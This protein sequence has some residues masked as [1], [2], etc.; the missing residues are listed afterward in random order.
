MCQ[1]VIAMLG[2]TIRDL[3]C[4]FRLFTS[5]SR[6]PRRGDPVPPHLDAPRGRDRRARRRG[7]PPGERLSPGPLPGGIV[8]LMVGLLCPVYGSD[9]PCTSRRASGGGPAPGGFW[10]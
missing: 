8:M 3:F 9:T 5:R 6:P 1:I 7:V 4:S 10:G 2:S